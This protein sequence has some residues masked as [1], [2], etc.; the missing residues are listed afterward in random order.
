MSTLVFTLIRLGFLVLIWLFIF[1]VMFTLRRDIYGTELRDRRSSSR[2]IGQQR[3]QHRRNSTSSAPQSPQS[4]PRP[5]RLTVTDGPLA[6]TTLP[7]GN[8]H[9]VVGRSPDCALVLNDAYSSSR[10]ARFYLNNGQWWVEDLDSTNGTFIGGNRITSPQPLE[11]G[12]PVII[13]HTTVEIS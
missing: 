4:P 11:P 10:H 3:R 1:S 2:A 12:T 7:L 5:A 8:A 9:I 13:G 6:G